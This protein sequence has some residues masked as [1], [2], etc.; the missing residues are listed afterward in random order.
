M[1]LYQMNIQACTPLALRVMLFIQPF[2]WLLAQWYT[3]KEVE[4]A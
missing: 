3:A 1:L 4:K 2:L